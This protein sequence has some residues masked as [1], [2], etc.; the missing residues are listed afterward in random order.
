M[1]SLGEQAD[2]ETLLYQQETQQSID[3][4]PPQMDEAATAAM[5]DAISTL[6][7]FSSSAQHQLQHGDS[8]LAE[9]QAENSTSLDQ[10]DTLSAGAPLDV[11]GQLEQDEAI[12]TGSSSGALSEFSARQQ[13]GS[14]LSG[15]SSSRHKQLHICHICS[16]GCPSKHKLK[17]HLC[18]HS[19][20]RPFNCCVCNKSFKWTEYLQKHMRQ[21]HPGTA[22][23][24]LKEGW[25]YSFS[26]FPP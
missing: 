14:P 3:I 8:V 6:A 18:T 4:E 7:S 22:E 24:K 10:L 21:Q 17:R 15:R 12:V 1:E 13:A 19:E 20:D 16:R 9:S 2:V 25:L 5:S 26:S 11:T 23:R